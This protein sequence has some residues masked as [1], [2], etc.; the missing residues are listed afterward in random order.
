MLNERYIGSNKITLQRAKFDFAKI[1]E[2]KIRIKMG[3]LKMEKEYKI[4]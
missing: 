1:K 3:K 2:K 4:I